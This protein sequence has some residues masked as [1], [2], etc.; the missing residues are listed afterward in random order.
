MTGE[1]ARLTSADHGRLD[2]TAGLSP[3]EL[4]VIAGGQPKGYHECV[5]GSVGGGG[6]GLYPLYIEC[7]LK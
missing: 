2:E 6:P 7:R 3:A 1:Y 4:D 5:I